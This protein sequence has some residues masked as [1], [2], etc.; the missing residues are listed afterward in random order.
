MSGTTLRALMSVGTL[1]FMQEHFH[2]VPF[3]LLDC[4]ISP[5]QQTVVTTQTYCVIRDF[6]TNYKSSTR[7]RLVETSPVF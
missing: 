1:G 5:I 4:I 3:L 2:D 6:S 7:L